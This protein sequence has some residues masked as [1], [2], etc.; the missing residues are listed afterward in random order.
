MF[1][2]LNLTTKIAIG[3]S[4]IIIGML[5]ISITS[6]SGIHKIDDEIKEIA[7]YEQPLAENIV[8]IEKHILKEEIL[9]DELVIASKNIHSNRFKTLEEHIQ[10]QAQKA[11]T[12][13]KKCQHLVSKGEK[14]TEDPNTQEKYIQVGKV[15]SNLEKEQETFNHKFKILLN[16]VKQSNIT[17]MEHEETIMK[18]QLANMSSQAVSIVK[19]MENLSNYLEQQSEDNENTIITTLEIIVLI[20]LL[21]ALVIAITLNKEIKTKINNFQTG[22]L[23]FFKYLNR[24]ATNVEILDDSSSDEIGTMAKVVN[25][26]IIKTQNN[27]EEERKVI[28]DT[29]AVLSEFEQGDLCQRVKASTSNPALQELTNLLNQMAINIE[30]NIDGVLNILEQYSNSNYMNKVDTKGIKAHLLK[31][32]NGVN[33]LGDAITS[34]LIENKQNGLTLDKSSDILLENVEILNNNSNQAA[35]ALEETSAALEEITS[36]IASNTQN[37]VKMAGYANQL[38][39]SS[40]Q[41]KILATKTTEAMNDIDNEVNSINEAI[42]V[43]DQIAFQ[44]NIL[45]LNAAVEA[46]TAGEAGKGFAVVAQE[47]RNLASRSAEAANEI[48][49][50]VENATS[51]ANYG[52]SIADQMIDGYTGLNDNISKTIDLISDVEAASKEQLM[53]I[54]QINDAVNAL[55]QQ[56]Q[57]NATI[58]SQTHNVAIQTDS[59]AKLVVKNANDKEFIGKNSVKSKEVET[60]AIQTKDIPIANSEPKKEPIKEITKEK[61]PTIISSND[62]DE[63]E[64]F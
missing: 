24:E 17:Q 59:L 2:N 56:T 38:T 60:T 14:S 8:D 29:I 48:K 63:W 54:E 32:A 49:N 50:L 47:V 22:L 11:D 31:L 61:T 13:T 19:K 23:G 42:S 7:Q 64:D 30:T 33:T 20:V 15:C 53:G 27:I 43:I 52:K 35:V 12:L 25:E 45:S 3:L 16:N 57:Q 5:I 62:D 21:I 34:M 46:A 26:N 28:N 51:K 1:K 4:A 18:N 37:I 10:Q 58:A 9:I 6:Y 36:N 44:T 41:G 40:S 55:D 39:T